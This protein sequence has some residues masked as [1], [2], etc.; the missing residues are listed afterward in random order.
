MTKN[1]TSKKE[2][3]EKIKGYLGDRAAELIDEDDEDEG[4]TL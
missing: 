3:K 1:K 4:T 2:Q